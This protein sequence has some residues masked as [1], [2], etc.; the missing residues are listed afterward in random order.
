MLQDRMVGLEIVLQFVNR[1]KQ[2]RA[3][4]EM[5]IHRMLFV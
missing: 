4:I 5:F 2:F 3:K 1:P